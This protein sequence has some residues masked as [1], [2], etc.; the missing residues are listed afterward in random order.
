MVV[1]RFFNSILNQASWIDIEL[2]VF[3]IVLVILLIDPF[4]GEF[5]PLLEDLSFM[6][7]YF[8]IFLAI[9]V[10]GLCRIT[11]VILFITFLNFDYLLV[12]EYVRLF[13]WV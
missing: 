11:Y 6:C 1:L 7:R 2:D 12:A 8:V 9:L 10:N 13:P 3:I 5:F 4:L